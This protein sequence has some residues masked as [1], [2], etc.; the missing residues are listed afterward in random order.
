MLIFHSLPEVRI[1]CPFGDVTENVSFGVGVVLPDDAPGPLFQIAG[2]PWAVQI[3]GGDQKV[4]HVHP[5]PHF[6]GAAH[7]DAYLPS[8]NLG[9]QLLFLHFGVG[10]MNERDLTGGDAP[11]DEL[12][13]DVRVNA[14]R[15]RRV[16]LRRDVLQ[17]VKFRAACEFSPGP[18]RPA[19]LGGGAALWGGDVAEYKLGQL[20]VQ[21]VVPES[22][23][24]VDA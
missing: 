12:V 9:E 5:G 22:E 8:A 10:V 21:P 15:F 14:E 4:L 23:N 19:F 3:V 17:S 16:G 24:V 20:F 2:T 1:E 18:D 6:G 11:R 7:E 13:P